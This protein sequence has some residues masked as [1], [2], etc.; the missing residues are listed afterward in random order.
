MARKAAM[1]LNRAKEAEARAKKQQREAKR[2]LN[3]EIAQAFLKGFPIL[4]DVEAIP[5]VDAFVAHLVALNDANPFDASS[6]DAASDD[7]AHEETES[8]VFS[9][10]TSQSDAASVSTESNH[11]DSHTNF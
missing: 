5:D 7:A 6:E 8:S 2:A 11:F 9:N 10:Q 3:E 4:Q 1:A